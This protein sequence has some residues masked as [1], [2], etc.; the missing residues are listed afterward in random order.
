[1]ARVPELPPDVLK[2]EDAATDALTVQLKAAGMDHTY[3]ELPPLR[4]AGP[5]LRIFNYFLQFIQFVRHLIF[6]WFTNFLCVQNLSYQSR[7]LF[8]T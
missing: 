4:H 2:A 8:Y 7:F 1:M 6:T 3:A 5:L